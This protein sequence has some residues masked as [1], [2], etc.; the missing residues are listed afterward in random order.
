MYIYVYTHTHTH[1]HTREVHILEHNAKTIIQRKQASISVKNAWPG[2]SSIA[3]LTHSTHT[4]TNT[5]RT[6]AIAHSKSLKTRKK[7]LTQ[8]RRDHVLFL[9]ISLVSPL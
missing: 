5:K 1:T 9:Q 6:N 8:G 7:R 4:H 2:K 3:T